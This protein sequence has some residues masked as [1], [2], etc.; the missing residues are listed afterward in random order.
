LEELDGWGYNF[1]LQE[2]E[3]LQGS[4]RGFS[5]RERSSPWDTLL[6]QHDDSMKIFANYAHLFGDAVVIVAESLGAAGF[7]VLHMELKLNENGIY[8]CYKLSPK[9]G[10]VVK[11]EGP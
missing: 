1:D 2:Q 11:L 5:Q 6:R 3:A 9:T 4:T 8:L 10:I 7:V